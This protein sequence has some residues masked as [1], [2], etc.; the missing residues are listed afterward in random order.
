MIMSSPLDSFEKMQKSLEKTLRITETFNQQASVVNNALRSL[1]FSPISD[2]YSAL[3]AASSPSIINAAKALS[4]SPFAS[5]IESLSLSG[6]SAAANA[7]TNSA[8]VRVAKCLSTPT[9]LSDALNISASIPQAILDSTALAQKLANQLTMPPVYSV[10]SIAAEISSRI[11]NPVSGAFTSS[12][13]DLAV[14]IREMP[15][16]SFEYSFDDAGNVNLSEQLENKL[17]DIINVDPAQPDSPRKIISKEFF[18]SVVVPIVLALIQLGYNV[19]SDAQLT[20]LLE[21]Q[22]QEKMTI[23]RQILNEEHQQTEYLRRISESSKESIPAE[24]DSPSS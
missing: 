1:S 22:H 2:Y 11:I 7:L 4:S 5:V 17:S 24:E 23:Q 15:I 18:Y 8:T 6:V 13:L 20:E 19:Y 12:F 9:L 16:D 3:S 21:H 10:S 14:D